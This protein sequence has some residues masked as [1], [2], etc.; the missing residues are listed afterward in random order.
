MPARS[1]VRDRHVP[2]GQAV[3]ADPQRDRPGS[4][5]R[6]AQGCERPGAHRTRVAEQRTSMGSET[7]QQRLGLLG[8][9]QLPQDA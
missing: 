2:S 6:S 5:L 1:T 8:R 7:L 9:G 4:E 3:D